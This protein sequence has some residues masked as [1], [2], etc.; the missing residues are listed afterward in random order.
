MQKLRNSVKKKRITQQTILLLGDIFSYH[1]VDFMFCD[2]VFDRGV[3]DVRVRCGITPNGIFAA[4]F[5]S[6]FRIT[7]IPIKEKRNCAIPF[8]M[9]PFVKIARVPFVFH[10]HRKFHAHKNSI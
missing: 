8:P 10:F 3:I 5:C 9:V 4:M 6:E 7:V 1:N 2:T